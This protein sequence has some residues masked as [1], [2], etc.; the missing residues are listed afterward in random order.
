[1][2]AD[3]PTRSSFQ[4]SGSLVRKRRQPS[5][6]LSEPLAYL[7]LVQWK[8]TAGFRSGKRIVRS[9]PIA[10]PDVESERFD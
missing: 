7:T 5:I 4:P 1:M 3:V 6:I 8:P 2:P 9:T 10:M